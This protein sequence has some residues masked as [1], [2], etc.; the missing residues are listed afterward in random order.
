MNRNTLE[1]LEKTLIRIGRN[2]LKKEGKK[3]KKSAGTGS[4]GKKLLSNCSPETI[5]LS[6][7]DG[8]LAYDIKE[9]TNSDWE[10]GMQVHINEQLSLT[11]KVLHVI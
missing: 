9:L 7:A 2:F 1:P 6:R 8:Q 4:G 5:L 10:S 11:G 3:K